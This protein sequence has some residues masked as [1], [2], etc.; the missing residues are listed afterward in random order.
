MRSD[1]WINLILHDE[2]QME[3]WEGCVQWCKYRDLG[4]RVLYVECIYDNRGELIH[5]RTHMTRHIHVIFHPLECT[6][7]ECGELNAQDLVY[8]NDVIGYYEAFMDY[9][10][11]ESRRRSRI[12]NRLVVLVVLRWWWGSQLHLYRAMKLSVQLRSV[13]M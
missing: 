5:N 3:M 12:S 8:Y 13:W 4:V 9:G 1:G 11:I 6:H 7:F 2:S 10:Y